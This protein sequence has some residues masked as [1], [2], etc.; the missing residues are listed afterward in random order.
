MDS[1]GPTRAFA[2]IKTISCSGLVRRLSIPAMPVQKV[3]HFRNC[4]I[5]VPL[6]IPRGGRV[7]DEEVEL[8]PFGPHCDKDVTGT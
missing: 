2:S 6:A 1:Q 8:A 5:V 7:E 4:V 3:A